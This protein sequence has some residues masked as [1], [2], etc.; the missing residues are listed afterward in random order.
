M[1]LPSSDLPD[2]GPRRVLIAGASGVGKTSVARRV[3]QVAGLPHTEID[4]LFHGPNW[5][6]LPEFVES[7]EAFT[8]EER[9]VTEWQY[10]TQLG[11]LLTSRADTLVLLDYSVATHMWRLVRRTLRRRLRRI[12]L[13][14]GNVEPPLHT[15]VT[16]PEHIIRWGWKGRAKLRRRVDAAERS[17]PNLRVVRL[18]S[19]AEAN[20]WL[21]GLRRPSLNG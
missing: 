11:D 16:D 8:T 1:V 10:A 21:L 6:M 19:Q 2:P 3:E 4:A 20:E 18:R 7:V 15:I 5:T 17:W 14:N 13:W 9:W 12:E